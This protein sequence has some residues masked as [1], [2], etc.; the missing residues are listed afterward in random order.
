MPA[1]VQVI[2][3]VKHYY[4]GDVT[5]QA[6]SGVNLAFDEGDFVALMG[7]SGSG[8]S[9]LMNVLGC[10]DRPTSGQYV[11]RDQNVADMTDDE[12]S[13]VR[14]TYLG[15]IFQAYNLLPQYTVV[16]NIE[17]PLLYQG[18]RLDE[19]THA[20]CV[21]LSEM[22]GLGDRLDHRPVQ[23]SG[24]QQQRVAI[25]RALVNDP[26]LILA[27][28]PTGNLDSRTSDEIMHMLADLNRAGKTIIM[29]TH[30][31]DIA[32]WARRVVRM[33]DGMIESD[34]RNDTVSF[35]EMR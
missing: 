22:V 25:A 33:R 23:L 21:A 6:L 29:V 10:L 18:V 20:R 34:E 19:D 32:A 14:S 1:I 27:D 16:E 5:V 30:E 4:M 13:E 11:L 2:D 28:E 31:N 17:I 3:L 8:K 15:F 9:T 35:A 24:G 12:L 7:P 26:Q